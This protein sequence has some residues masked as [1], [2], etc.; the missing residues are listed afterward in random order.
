MLKTVG[1]GVV[2]ALLVASGVSADE[3]HHEDPT[4]IVT[5]VGAGYSDS[6]FVSG[7]IGLDDARML[8]A[9]YNETGEWRLGGSWLFEL[10]IVNFNFSR[11]D[12]EHESYRNNYSIGTYIPL[13]YFDIAPAGWMLFPMA[14]YSYND[15]EM[16]VPSE[17]VE[18]E[19][20]LMRSQTHG[21]YLGMF[22]VRPIEDT[23][24]SVLSFAGGSIGS[25]NYRSY[26][27]GLGL[28]YKLSR[29]TSFNCFGVLAE[30]DYGT[31]NKLA[32]SVSYEF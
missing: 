2:F 19:F 27:G 11:T 31:N 25:N 17:E 22:G 15:G 9:R 32:G 23:D 21:A 24:W 8:N 7:S 29:H 12:Y 6:S 20:V 3:K 4:K 10:G 30:D 28:S 5:K 13:S 26:W 14:G 18:N 1:F 16:A